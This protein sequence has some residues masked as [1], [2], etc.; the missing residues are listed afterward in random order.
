MSEVLVPMVRKSVT[1]V[2]DKTFV[3]FYN[4]GSSIQDVA[5]H[6]GL[7]YGGVCQKAKGLR[8]RGL[9]GLKVYP[10][11]HKSSTV[12]VTELQKFVD[13]LNTISNVDN[14]DGVTDAAWVPDELTVVDQAVVDVTNNQ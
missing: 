8:D 7:S 4:S 2:D 1:R 3:R 9:Q 12:D 13:E 6:T 5:D 14:T 11:G 10:K